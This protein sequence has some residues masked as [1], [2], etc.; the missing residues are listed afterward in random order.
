MGRDGERLLVSF[1]SIGPPGSL[2]VEERSLGV[3]LSGLAGQFQ[4]SQNRSISIL[5]TFPGHERHVG[6]V[7]MQEAAL[8]RSER[9]R[10]INGLVLRGDLVNFQGRHLL[11]SHAAQLCGLK[12]ATTRQHIPEGEI[13]SLACRVVREVV[14]VH[15]LG[16]NRARCV[17]QIRAAMFPARY[18]PG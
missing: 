12:V 3:N 14:I 5:G 17:G 16:K 7:R 6:L 9:A 4:K 8:R 1:Q 15:D 2:H 11:A 18:P 13:A 10:R